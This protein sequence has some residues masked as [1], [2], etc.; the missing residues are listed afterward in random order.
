MSFGSRVVRRG[1]LAKRDPAEARATLAQL[2]VLIERDF[3]NSLAFV[4]II[5]GDDAHAGLAGMWRPLDGRSSQPA[6]KPCADV[7]KTAEAKDV[8]RSVEFHQRIHP[9][10]RRDVR[11][12]IVVDDPVAAFQ[13][14]S[15]IPSRRVDSSIKRCCGR[16]SS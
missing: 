4:V 3:A 11:D 6:S 14:R 10:E 15:R 12:R 16:L 5:G 9:A 8:T 2:D 1:G 13:P 7:R